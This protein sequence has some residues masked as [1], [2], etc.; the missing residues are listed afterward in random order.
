MINAI[1]GLISIPIMLLNF[2]GGI[3]GGIWLATLG[4]WGLLGLGVASMLL[5]SSGLSLVLTP[6]LL[7][8][9]PGG[10]A[11]DRGKYVVGFLCLALSNL[12][13]YIVMIVWS[14]GCFKVVL[15]YYDSGS[16]WPYLLWAYGM[17]TGPWTYMAVRGGPGETG[18]HLSAFG[19]CVGAVAI[20]GVL[21]LKSEPTIIDA[22]IAFCVPMFVVF[23]FQT[24]VGFLIMREERLRT[25]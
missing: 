12:W 2:G 14:V 18:S 21:L 22:A 5:S 3:V 13:V 1:L 25:T 4:K 8:A 16:I 7:F 9:V 15:G 19:A 20:M 11:L 23:I 17:A 6:G 10:L 24:V